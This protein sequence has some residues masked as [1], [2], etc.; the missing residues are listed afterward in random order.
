[1]ESENF[2]FFS[3]KISKLINYSINCCSSIQDNAENKKNC[4]FKVNHFSNHDNIANI[5]TSY[6]HC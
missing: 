3:L 4:V 5:E 2:D 6:K 1:M